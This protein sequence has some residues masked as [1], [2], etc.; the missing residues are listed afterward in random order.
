MCEGVRWMRWC[1][2]DVRVCEAHQDTL[3][4]VRVCKGC[5]GV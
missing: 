3:G 5:D 2:K 1:V 4:S